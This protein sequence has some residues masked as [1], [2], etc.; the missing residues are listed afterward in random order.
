ML[1][2]GPDQENHIFSGNIFIFHAFDVGYDIDLEKVKASSSII[3]RPLILPKF[4][5]NYHVPLKIDLPHPHSSSRYN[6]AHLYAFGALS[7]MY[8]IPFQS[9][10]EKIRT[11][12][13]KIDNTY[14]EQS[15]DDAYSIFKKIKKHTTHPHFFY[16]RSSYLVVQINTEPTLFNGEKLRK[17][18]GNIITSMLRL[19]TETLSKRQKEEVLDSSMSYFSN[20]LIVIDTEAAFIYDPDYE[21]ILTFFEFGNIQQLELRYFDR[22]LDK[23]LNVMYEEPHKKIPLT[24]Y[25]PLFGIG[26]SKDPVRELG[27]LKV[28]I[29]VITE[30]LESSIKLA[31][32]PYFSELYALIVQELDLQQWRDSIDKKLAIILDIRSILQHKI[33]SIREDLL[34][35]LII[36]LIFVELIVALLHYLSG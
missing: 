7:I 12:L 15:V 27:Q 19:E 6:R 10:L 11:E 20:D 23:Q 24:S 13:E 9:S 8:K 29:S 5:K 14:R 28:D 3:A 18:Y 2:E 35:I 16:I 30:R 31:G 4:F 1:S 21:D 22:L 26:S 34:S 32:E 25:L 36:V 33:D 17:Q